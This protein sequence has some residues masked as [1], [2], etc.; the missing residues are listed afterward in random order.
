MIRRSGGIIGFPSISPVKNFLKVTNLLLSKLFCFT[1]GKKH[2]FLIRGIDIF[3][4]I[5]YKT[6]LK[7]QY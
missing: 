4:I 7:F 2:K 5:T 6:A 3:I 1:S